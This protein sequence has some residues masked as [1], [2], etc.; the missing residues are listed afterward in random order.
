MPCISSTLRDLGV[1]FDKPLLSRSPILV[2][3]DRAG[4]SDSCYGAQNEH[5]NTQNNMIEGEIIKEMTVDNNQQYQETVETAD[6][7]LCRLKQRDDWMAIDIILFRIN[8]WHDELAIPDVE[9][10]T[11]VSSYPLLE[12]MVFDVNISYGVAKMSAAIP[13]GGIVRLHQCIK[14][15]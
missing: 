2:G 6:N 11:H 14:I 1:I 8:K 13:L 15:C 5:K 4:T 12:S 9:E 7:M 10:F 3:A